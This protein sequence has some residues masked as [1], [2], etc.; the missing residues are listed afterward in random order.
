VAGTGEG[1]GIQGSLQEDED[2]GGG[3]GV[4]G[5]YVIIYDSSLL[6]DGYFYKGVGA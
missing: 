1:E 3:G 2:D 5:W 4:G 6:R